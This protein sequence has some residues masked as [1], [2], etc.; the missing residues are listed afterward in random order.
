MMFPIE[1]DNKIWTAGIRS[2]YSI[3]GSLD[4][5]EC[6]PT[7]DIL[8]ITID[9]DVLFYKVEANEKFFMF[10]NLRVSGEIHNA[11]LISILHKFKNLSNLILS[12]NFTGIVKLETNLCNKLKKLEIIPKTNNILNL[13]LNCK[14]LDTIG[15][16]NVESIGNIEVYFKYII[17]NS[18]KN[19][20]ISSKK[21][22]NEL[23]NTFYNLFKKTPYQISNLSFDWL[24]DYIGIFPLCILKNI[25]S[26]ISRYG[27][28]NYNMLEYIY[29]NKLKVNIVFNFNN[30]QLLNIINTKYK[31]CFIYKDDKDLNTV[32]IDNKSLMY[33]HKTKIL[34]ID[35]IINHNALIP[36]LDEC[37]IRTIDQLYNKMIIC[38]IPSLINFRLSFITNINIILDIPIDKCYGVLI[39]YCISIIKELYNIDIDSSFIDNLYKIINLCE[40]SNN[41]PRV[42]LVLKY[43]LNNNVMYSTMNYYLGASH[44]VTYLIDKVGISHNNNAVRLLFAFK[45]FI[46]HNYIQAIDKCRTNNYVLKTYYLKVEKIEY[47][48]TVLLNNKYDYLLNLL[49]NL[50]IIIK[51]YMC[52]REDDKLYRAYV[53][54]E[55]LSIYTLIYK[56]SAKYNIISLIEISYSENCSYDLELS[57][58]LKEISNLLLTK[59][60]ETIVS[61]MLQEFDNTN[62]INIYNYVLH[63]Q[64]FINIMEQFS[65]NFNITLSSLKF[66]ANKLINDNIK[67]LRKC[68]KKLLFSKKTRELVIKNNRRKILEHII[69]EDNAFITY[70]LNKV[71]IFN[72]T[73][74]KYEDTIFSN[75]I[76]DLVCIYKL[77]EAN[78]TDGYSI[79]LLREFVCYKNKLNNSKVNLEFVRLYNTNPCLRDQMD[80]ETYNTNYNLYL[81]HNSNYKYV[82]S[83]SNILYSRAVFGILSVDQLDILFCDYNSFN[84]R[85]TVNSRYDS[86]S[87]YNEIIMN[88]KSINLYP[89]KKIYNKSEYKKYFSMLNNALEYS[90][91]R[92]EH[93][94]RNYLNN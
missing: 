36:E 9:K 69:K 14:N 53:E 50:F 13:I 87:T 67:V 94:V 75:I 48:N 41:D 22:Y 33:L 17:L 11:T 77:S 49:L 47:I 64:K 51:K 59:Y 78:K 85:Y 31:K 24:N 54:F 86:C 88:T 46:I 1:T 30:N 15:L 90:N 76:L 71:L 21:Y 70:I 27:T 40:I 72:P 62:N 63:K 89:N 4:I 82:T 29:T 56:E 92:A 32:N 3:I 93:L 81:D 10:K 7:C 19:I 45:H 61:K 12:C 35:P 5:K 79:D 23:I 84:L 68:N 80:V 42:Y 8:H 28:L 55:M 25:D 37:L 44:V 39:S 6:D 26:I 57:T 20:K 66:N 38:D 34:S 18:I 83:L 43:Y 60:S 74:N 16:L 58:I 65:Q 2:N 73:T 91:T 52:I